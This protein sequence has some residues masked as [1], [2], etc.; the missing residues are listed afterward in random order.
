M[1]FTPQC[2]KKFINDAK[3]YKVLTPEQENNATQEQ[4][5]KH[6]ML[7][8]VKIA[9][10]FTNSN[11]ELN[12][13]VSEGMIGLIMASKTHDKTRGFKFISYASFLIRSYMLLFIR[14]KKNLIRIPS[15]QSYMN[16]K[17]GKLIDTHSEEE[18]KK[19]L[20]IDDFYI[21]YYHY[22]P[23]V[24]SMDAQYD[25]DSD[26]YVKQYASDSNPLEKLE[27]QYSKDVVSKILKCLSKTE[28]EIIRMRYFEM[29]PMNYKQIGDNLGYSHQGVK[30]IYD[31]AMLKLKQQIASLDQ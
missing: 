16:K 17:I 10:E 19:I 31:R 8:V 1:S 26:S 15:N 28:L 18:I 13:L 14:N 22:N 12:D 7:F 6:N 24:E 2:I 4:L 3:K 21:K 11:C 29:Y 20:G 27:K 25:L 30:N 9:K 23:K 5:I